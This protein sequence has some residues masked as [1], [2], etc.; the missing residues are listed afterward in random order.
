MGCFIGCIKEWYDFD[1]NLIVIIEFPGLTTNKL[2]KFIF[3]GAYYTT[4]VITYKIIVCNF[5]YIFTYL[6]INV[7]LLKCNFD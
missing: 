4:K 5:L 2:L 7:K 6:Q 3:R 1:S